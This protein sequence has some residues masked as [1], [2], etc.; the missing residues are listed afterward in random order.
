M[1]NR[2]RVLVACVWAACSS[3]VDSFSS[4]HECHRS[5]MTAAHQETGS[6]LD[7]SSNTP[8][9]DASTRNSQYLEQSQS[10]FAIAYLNEHHKDVLSSFVMAFSEVGELSVSKNM[11]MGGSY[12]L[13]EAKLSGITRD[14]LIIEATI[15]ESGKSSKQQVEV[16]LDSSPVK[17]MRKKF[18]ELPPVDGAILARSSQLP[19]DDFVRRMVRLCNQA[20]AYSATGKMIQLGVQ[21]GG[22]GAGK[23]KDNM[24]LNQV[25]HSE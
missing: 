11:W 16:S 8:A 22:K 5:R 25:P 24:F 1:V 13:E 19:I 12:V 7:A 6:R 23:L 4:S 17:G 3:P 9:E 18:I 21:L 2:R 14:S 10:E 20:K 15:Q